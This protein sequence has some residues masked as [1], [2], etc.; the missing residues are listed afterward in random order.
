M[1]IRVVYS[2]VALALSLSSAANLQPQDL[3]FF[4]THKRPTQIVG[5]DK[6]A[7][8]LTESGVLFY[9]YRRQQWIDNLYPNAPVSAI[10]YSTSKSKVYLLLAGGRTLEYNS[11]FHRLTDVSKQDYNAASDGGSAPDLT[12]LTLDGNNLFMGDGVRDKYMRRVP[13]TQSRVFEYDNLWILTDGLGA[14]SGSIRRKQ[15]ASFWFG[16]DN[17]AAQVIYHEGGNVWFGSCKTDL[18]TSS[19]LASS[20][21]GALVTAK[22]DLTNWKM[23]PAQ[24][25]YGFVDGCIHDIKAWKNYI[26][27]AT[28]KGV[29]RHDPLTGQFR[30]YSH[31]QGGIDVRVNNLHIHEGF[32]YV[33]SDQGVSYLTDPAG[34]F[35]SVETPI[36]GGVP[37]YELES[38]D[39][40]LWAATRYG[41]YVHQPTGWK[42]FKEVSGK[43]VPEAFGVS[44]PSVL[45]H[46]TSIYWI[47][48]N[49]VMVKPKKQ[50]PRILLERDGPI[51][52]IAEGDV[53]FVAY[54][55][56]V[57]AYDLKKK[58][59]N[60]FTL[61][62]GI[63]GTRV[64]SISINEGKLW[65]GTD[66]GVERL[67]LKAYLP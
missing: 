18:A 19:G 47:S 35:Q 13:I 45:Y 52:L 1:N 11:V 37:V 23:F 10:R 58:L 51:R 7:Y 24:L 2:M 53:L 16:L 54:Q 49:K 27:L 63:P 14:F 22:S 30:V 3:F 59:W 34:E 65:I 48:A 61:A 33:G 50:L 15:A 12:G 25:E 67:N 32:L 40:D 60:D 6:N 29:I 41:L 26:W 9:D 62:D 44:V 21:N 8:I 38:K 4:S 66:K 36:Q 20:S 42:T 5:D 17:P 43:D 55:T 31:I 64:L 39:K 28:E 46:D 57:T 56:G